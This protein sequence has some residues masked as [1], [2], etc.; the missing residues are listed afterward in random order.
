MTE[1]LAAARLMSRLM[2]VMGAAPILAPTLGGI[3][4]ARRPGTRSSGSPPSM[5]AS[6][7]VLVGW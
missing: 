3:I 1:G 5:A 6:C 2:L 7:C 4:L